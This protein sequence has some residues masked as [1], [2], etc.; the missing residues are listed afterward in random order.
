MN[1]IKSKQTEAIAYTFQLTIPAK[2]GRR[3]F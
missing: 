2:Q 3:Y 1:L